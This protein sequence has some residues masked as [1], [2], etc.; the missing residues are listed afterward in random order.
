MEI[1]KRPEISAQ[2]VIGMAKLSEIYRSAKKHF[3]KDCIL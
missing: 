1:L 2:M 3:L